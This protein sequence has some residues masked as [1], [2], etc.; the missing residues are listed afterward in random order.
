MKTPRQFGAML[1]G[2]RLGFRAL[3]SIGM[4]RVSSEGPPWIV[5][6]VPYNVMP[7]AS[8]P[9]FAEWWEDAEVIG[10]LDAALTRVLKGVPLKNAVVLKFDDELNIAE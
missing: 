6:V 2:Y 10:L 1:R 9:A 4:V 5:D 7:R 8:T 3:G